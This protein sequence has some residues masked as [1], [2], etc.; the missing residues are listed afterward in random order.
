M[1]RPPSYDMTFCISK[2]NNEKCERNFKYLIKP[3]YIRFYSLAKLKGTECCIQ[4]KR[5][6]NE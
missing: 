1:N 4:N 3:R 6:N 2:C 5:D